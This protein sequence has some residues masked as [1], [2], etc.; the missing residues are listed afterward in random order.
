MLQSIWNERQSIREN[1][2]LEMVQHNQDV[3]LPRVSLASSM[4]LV[5]LTEDLIGSVGIHHIIIL[6]LQCHSLILATIHTF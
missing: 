1:S 4:D 2:D 3:F 5:G 6:F